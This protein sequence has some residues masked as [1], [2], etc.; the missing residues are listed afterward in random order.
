M[1]KFKPCHLLLI[2]KVAVVLYGILI[3]V[4]RRLKFSLYFENLPAQVYWERLISFMI[5]LALGLFA[6]KARLYRN[7]FQ[8]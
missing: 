7:K 2:S 4:F 3:V 6:I 8:V 5:I 1:G